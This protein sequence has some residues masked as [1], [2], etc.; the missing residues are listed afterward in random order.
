MRARQYCVSFFTG[1]FYYGVLP[2]AAIFS[3]VASVIM[4]CYSFKGTLYLLTGSISVQH[5]DMPE[6]LAVS[7]AELLV[8]IACSFLGAGVMWL[9]TRLLER[10]RVQPQ[11]PRPP[12]DGALELTDV[13][14]EEEIKGL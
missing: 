5:Y 3:V 4:N 6:A 12:S 14:L 13:S 10:H 9:W 1:A 8:G 7:R 2:A 11:Q